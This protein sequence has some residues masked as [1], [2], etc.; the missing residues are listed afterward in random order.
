M[1]PDSTY[2][3]TRPWTTLGMSVAILF[4][5]LLPDDCTRLRR[6]GAIY[7]MGFVVY[8]LTH[9]LRGWVLGQ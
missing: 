1:L 7:L 9:N 4:A 8:L 6:A 2:H 5:L 3:A